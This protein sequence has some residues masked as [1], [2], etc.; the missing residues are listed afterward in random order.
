MSLSSLKN[1]TRKHNNSNSQQGYYWQKIVET[2]SENK[3]QQRHRQQANR[4]VS[5]PFLWP[6][7]V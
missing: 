1:S 7:S 6:G 4:R 3:S 2:L 5:G